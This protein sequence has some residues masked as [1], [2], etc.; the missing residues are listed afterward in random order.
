[1][2]NNEIIEILLK[3]LSQPMDTFMRIEKLN[4]LRDIACRE[5]NVALVK[6]SCK[7]LINVINK[8]LQNLTFEQQSKAYT[9]LRDAHTIYGKYNFKSYLIAMEWDRPVE[10]RFYQPRMRVLETVVRDLQDLGDGVID[11]YVL[12][13]P[14]RVGKTTIG[15]LFI[16]WMM[17]RFP[18]EHVFA[19]GYASGLVGTFYNGVLDFVDSPEY[20]FYDIFPDARGKLS[21]SAENKTIDIY[22]DERYK[23]ATFRS[24]DGQITG[25]LEASSLLYLD[26]MCSGIEEAMNIDRLEKLWS[27]VTVDLKQRRVLNKRTKRLAPILAIGTIWSIHDPICRLKDDYKND[28][29]FRERVLPALDTD[30]ES[31]FDYDYDVGFSTESYNDM[32]RTM[33]EVSWECVYQQNPVERDGLLFA[34]KDLKRYLELPNQPPDSILAACDVAFGGDDFLSF[35]IV[36][37]YGTL[38]YVVDVVFRKQAGYKVTEPMVSGKIIL[39]KVQWAHFEANNGGDFYAR[40]VDNM[41]KKTSNHRCNITSSLASSKSSKLVRIIQYAPDIKELYFRDQS[42]YKAD[43]EYGKFMTNLTTFVQTGANANDDAPD[44]LASLCAML[45]VPR[46]GRITSSHT[47]IRNCM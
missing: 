4:L 45:K 33:D 27:K 35:P 37:M 24:I 30:G 34:A 40:D 3:Q 1:M 46:V 31:N 15:L 14:P 5:D 11:I 44:S 2:K 43:D 25:A 26:D 28:S 47:G 39:H 22:K 42:L 23:S 17:G 6:K 20:R 7:A 16:S 9:I 12:S 32:K 21:K 13:M 19:A 29:R 10:K 8:G 36:Y 38:G 41:V 18:D